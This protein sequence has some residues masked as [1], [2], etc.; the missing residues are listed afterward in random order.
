MALT[1]EEA[2]ATTLFDQSDQIA[3]EV[4][5]HNPLLAALDEQGNIRK[6]SGGYEIRKALM[7]NDTAVGSFYSGFESFALDAVN[8]ATA[9]QFNIKQCYEPMSISGRDRRANRDEEQLLD[10]VEMKMK[11]SIS[12]LKNT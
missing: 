12:R 7:Y 11:A 6:F 2:V 10:L 8:D 3:D 1:I 4:L 5:H 9:F